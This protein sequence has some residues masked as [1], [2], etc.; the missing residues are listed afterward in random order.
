MAN[1][2][3][4][5]GAGEYAAPKTVLGFYGAV[6]AI[7][8][9]GVIG[10]LA[11]LATN[12]SLHY[13]VPWVFGFAAVVLITLIGVVVTMNIRDPAK[14]QLGRVTARE[15]IEVQ[16]MTLGDSIAGSYVEEVP[17]IESVTGETADVRQEPL[18]E[19]EGA[20][21]EDDVDRGRDAS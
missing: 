17:A 8:E 11:V 4:G 3:K 18:P 20:E 14:L 13:L 12:D 15:Y 10:A 6:L 1:L 9:A 16:R 21:T 2:I 5:R 7:V 19:S